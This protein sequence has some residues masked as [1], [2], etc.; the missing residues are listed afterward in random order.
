M[1]LINILLMTSPDAHTS[2]FQSL[3]MLL[4]ILGLLFLITLS[5]WKIYEK[6]SKPGWAVLVPFYNILIFLEI[7]KKPWWW[8]ILLLIPYINIIWIIWSLNL[9]VKSFGDKSFW[10]VI[11][12]IFLPFIYLPLLAFDKKAVYKELDLNIK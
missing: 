7:I 5:M 11:G 9:F 1:E 4:L 8:L 2:G 12:I 3:I 10:S 6:A